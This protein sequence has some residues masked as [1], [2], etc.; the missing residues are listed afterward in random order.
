MT[1]TAMPPLETQRLLIRPFEMA[2]LED[3]YRI[4]DVEL[5]EDETGSEKMD[6]LAERA[7]WLKW[8]V[9]NYAQLALLYQPPYGDRAVVLRETG[10]LIG[11][12][13][14]VPCLMPFEQMPA[15]AAGTRPAIPGLATT[16]FGLFYAISPSQQRRGY[17]SE[18]A[19]A[20][21]DYAFQQLRLKRVVATTTYDN[22]GSMGVMRRLGMRIEKNPLPEP[23]YFQVVGWVNHP[24]EAR[25]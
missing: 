20:M 12:C 7:E 22:A 8:S 4:L 15:L 21:V 18:A 24:A 6:S 11:A 3:I 23:P 13:G 9:L 1:G 25:G 10:Q 2:D 17:A 19:Q 14:F 16:E 5:A